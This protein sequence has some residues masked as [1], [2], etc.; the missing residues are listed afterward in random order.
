MDASRSIITPTLQ[1]QAADLNEGERDLLHRIAEM[2]RSADADMTSGAVYEA[3][4]EYTTT[5]AT[6]YRTRLKRLEEAGL[7]DLPLRTDR[8]RTRGSCF[9]PEQVVAVCKKF[10]KVRTT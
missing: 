7:V 10:G 1:K 2:A 8:G 5:G 3:T 4:R 6:T 9:V